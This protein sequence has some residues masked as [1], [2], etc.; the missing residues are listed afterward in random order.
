MTIKTSYFKKM[1]FFRQSVMRNLWI[2]LMHTLILFLIFPLN[3]YF[4]TI[5]QE[6]QL[7][8][9]V[10]NLLTFNTKVELQILPFVL[11]PVLYAIISFKYLTQHHESVLVHSL[12][13]SR[14][15]L[16]Y[17]HYL[18][19]LFM[20]LLPLMING[21]FFGLLLWMQPSNHVTL[22]LIFDWLAYASLFGCAIYSL[23][24]FSIMIIGTP[25]LQLLFIFILMLLPAGLEVMIRS[26]MGMVIK[27][28]SEIYTGNLIV[29]L[30][31]LTGLLSFFNRSEYNPFSGYY[32][33][34]YG[35]Y[36]VAFTAIAYFLYQNRGIENAGQTVQFS[37]FAPILKYLATFCSTLLFGLILESIA[38]N[39]AGLL[40]GFLL[41]AIIGYI[42]S[43][44][45]LQKTIQCQLKL[46][47]LLLF[48]GLFGIVFM[49]L[50]TDLTGYGKKQY[51][52]EDIAAVSLDAYSSYSE[53]LGEDFLLKSPEAIEAVQTLYSKTISASS[54]LFWLRKNAQGFTTE[55]S[56]LF[57]FVNKN[58]QSFK[59]YFSL[60]AKLVQEELSALN[61]NPEFVRQKNIVLQMDFHQVD[62]LKMSSAIGGK[63]LADSESIVK[64]LKAYEQDLYDSYDMHSQSKL[65]SLYSFEVS[66]FANQGRQLK[67]NE[68]LIKWDATAYC[69]IYPYFERTIKVLESLPQLNHISVNSKKINAI[70]LQKVSTANNQSES[71]YI[72]KNQQ[73]D[74][75]IITDQK[76]IEKL[77]KQS[78]YHRSAEGSDYIINCFVPNTNGPVITGF[79]R[80]FE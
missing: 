12:P 55:K 39:P 44:M 14:K 68:A 65:Q 22:A 36:I 62:T 79:I 33:G 16:F 7:A 63:T 45:A 49:V 6:G 34:L 61:K 80:N 24:V 8:Q 53:P 42:L 43:N 58:G 57:S 46:K 59:R 3:V 75:I 19:G 64:L 50:A 51:K 23:S 17:E 73:N 72:D 32:L 38:N 21:L 60:D 18:S 52:L 5:N 30:S 10:F 70:W 15:R 31:P 67:S 27:G 71:A 29:N 40:I 48:I 66:L 76:T 26:I 28:Y 78:V 1:P 2:W 13:V 11:L 54:P 69:S 25:I 20:T 77:L 9:K 74:V 4:S 56:F 41:G 47:P 35:L 37:V